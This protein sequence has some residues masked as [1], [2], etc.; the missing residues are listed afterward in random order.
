MSADLLTFQTA[1]LIG[2]P[3]DGTT[4]E[5]PMHAIEIEHPD[6]GTYRYCPHAS[7]RFDKACFIHE[8]IHAFT[9]A[10]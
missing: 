2:G 4:I 7:A 3:D 10:P 5:V 1:T 8:T 9:Y 6:F